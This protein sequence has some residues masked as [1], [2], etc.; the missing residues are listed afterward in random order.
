[1][2]QGQC[3]S[4][5]E[6]I[7]ASNLTA[8]LARVRIGDEPDDLGD[9]PELI[10]ADG[11]YDGHDEWSTLGWMYFTLKLLTV[12][13]R[14][15]RGREN[16]VATNAQKVLQRKILNI[17]GDHLQD[18]DGIVQI[19]HPNAFGPIKHGYRGRSGVSVSE[20]SCEAFI[21]N[22]AADYPPA[23]AFAATAVGT[24]INL[25]W[26]NPS[27]R[28]DLVGV[29]IRRATGS[30]PATVND[31]TAVYTGNAGSFADTGLAE[32]TEYFYSC[33]GA[34]EAA[35]STEPGTLPTSA[36]T[37]SSTALT[38]SDTTGLN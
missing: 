30:A 37:Y 16:V 33:W 6:Y 9:R 5:I 31:G 26:T 10:I 14:G 18:S 11:G 3:L 2:D 4:Q 29:H 7:L 25:T 13:R 32:A 34:Y 20:I 12:S 38:A 21:G 19:E 23:I 36:D 15:V 28:F 24:T 27:T 1:M 17:I 22:D 8:E 35:P